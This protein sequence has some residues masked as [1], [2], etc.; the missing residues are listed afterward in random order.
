MEMNDIITAIG[1]LGFPI[2]ACIYMFRLNEKQNVAHH[3]EVNS[4]KDVINELKLA[5]TEL[6]D[7]IKK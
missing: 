6:T 2:V 4:L 3:D 5:I 7:F 1:S